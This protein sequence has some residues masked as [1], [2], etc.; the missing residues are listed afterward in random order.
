MYATCLFIVCILLAA[1]GVHSDR[2]FSL[3]YVIQVPE[4]CEDCLIWYQRCLAIVELITWRNIFQCSVFNC[5]Y[6]LE[7]LNISINMHLY[8]ETMN[9]Q[10][11]QQWS[12]FFT[13]IISVTQASSTWSCFMVFQFQSSYAL[14]FR[15]ILF[16]NKIS[17]TPQSFSCGAIDWCLCL[18]I[19]DHCLLIS[20]AA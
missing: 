2:S 19:N 13:L 3:L 7:K 10:S 17:F 12:F 16:H 6:F 5:N 1:L 11:S 9:C 18:L 14:F 15:S 8:V 20:Q 4:M